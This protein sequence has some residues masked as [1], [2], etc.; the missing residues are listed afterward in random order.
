MGIAIELQVISDQFVDD[1]VLIGELGFTCRVVVEGVEDLRTNFGPHLGKYSSLL[2]G[3]LENFLEF[4]NACH[5][6]YYYYIP[7]QSNPYPRT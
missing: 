7:G 1:H 6:N 5:S 3:F 4:V 2:Q